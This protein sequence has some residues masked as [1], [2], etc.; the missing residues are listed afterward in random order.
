[1]DKNNSSLK[2]YLDGS[3]FD[4]YSILKSS[5]KSENKYFSFPVM[6]ELSERLKEDYQ[7]FAKYFENRFEINDYWS[8]YAMIKLSEYMF[9]NLDIANARKYSS[10]SLRFDFDPVLFSYAKTNRAKNEWSFL[11]SKKVFDSLKI[12]TSN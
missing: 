1:M 2:K 7:L 3:D 9:E 5:N 8:S 12:Y 11:N 10:L 4:K 6:I